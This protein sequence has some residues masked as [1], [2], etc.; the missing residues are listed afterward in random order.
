MNDATVHIPVGVVTT[1]L[2]A[3]GVVVASVLTA[4]LA[5]RSHRDDSLRT[6]V[7]ALRGEVASARTET[8]AA[9]R[10][11]RILADYVHQLRTLL[12]EAGED[13]PPWPEGLTT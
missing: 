13:V 3:I 1:T 11:N 10:E 8:A 12:D 2:A 7:A 9:R 6:D 5:R 4:W